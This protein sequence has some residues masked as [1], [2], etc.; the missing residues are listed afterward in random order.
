MCVG[1]HITG[2]VVSAPFTSCHHNK[3][4]HVWKCW[5]TVPLIALNMQWYSPG[6]LRTYKTKSKLVGSPFPRKTRTRSIPCGDSGL[7]TDN[8]LPRYFLS[9]FTVYFNN[10]SVTSPPPWHLLWYLTGC[11][12]CVFLISC[13][14]WR[15]AVCELS[16]V[17]FSIWS[18]SLHPLSVRLFVIS[19]QQPYQPSYHHLPSVRSLCRVCRTIFVCLGTS[20]PAPLSAWLSR[21]KT[22]K[23]KKQKK[24]KE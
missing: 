13:L 19:N 2:M 10:G 5:R 18:P 6:L 21:A 1:W 23:A 9:T 12:E 16:F 24:K 8:T 20:S 4:D 15:T 3:S 22:D 14:F 17:V 7:C 11:C